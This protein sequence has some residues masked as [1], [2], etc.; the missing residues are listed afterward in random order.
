MKS[1]YRQLLLTLAVLL[2][3]QACLSL[4]ASG[5][6]P[7]KVEAID[8]ITSSSILPGYSPVNRGCGIPKPDTYSDQAAVRTPNLGSLNGHIF[9]INYDVPEKVMEIYNKL[10][11]HPNLQYKDIPAELLEYELKGDAIPEGLRKRLG[12]EKS[13]RT[14]ESTK[15]KKEVGDRGLDKDKDSRKRSEL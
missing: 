14:A 1:G 9:R 5:R 12:S 4:E 7:L 10:Y 2:Q 3:V 11:K 13:T 6:K 8:K 15:K